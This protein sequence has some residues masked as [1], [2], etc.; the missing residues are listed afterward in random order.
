MLFIPVF[1]WHQVYSLENSNNKL[2]IS[3]NFWYKPPNS[4]FFTFPGKRL[5]AQ[6]PA[7]LKSALKI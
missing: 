7:I 3:V 5:A 4:Q 6:I 1:W 2:N